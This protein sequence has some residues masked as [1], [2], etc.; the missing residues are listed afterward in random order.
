MLHPSRLRTELELDAGAGL[1]ARAGRVCHPCHGPGKRRGFT[2]L[3][4]M[5][6]LVI[7]GVGVLAFVDAQAAFTQSNTWSSQTAT[8]MYLANE[9][10]EMT[11]Q[12]SRHDRVTGLTLNGTTLTGWGR[13]TGEVAV[14]DMDDLDDMDGVSF[15]EDGIFAGPVDAFGAVIPEVALDGTIVTGN[16]GAPVPLRGW[17]QRVMVQKVD[18]YNYSTNRAGNY[19]Q[20]ATGQL[21]LIR[22][23]SF[24][25]RVTVV[26]EYTPLDTGQPTEIT[27]TTWIVPP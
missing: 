19:Q 24:P 16:G 18:P 1:P 13:E 23:D 6:A 8:G 25:L 20:A 2:L 9:V 12:M 14:D 27:R 17:T 10:R 4:S 21:P 22:V 15:G 11:R 7:I 5:M 3:E 26:V